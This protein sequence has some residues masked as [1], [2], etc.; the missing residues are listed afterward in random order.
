MEMKVTRRWQLTDLLHICGMENVSQSNYGD[1]G[2]DYTQSRTDPRPPKLVGKTSV[3][4]FRKRKGL[5]PDTSRVARHTLFEAMQMEMSGDDRTLHW[6]QP[7]ECGSQ[8]QTALEDKQLPA[9][10]DRRFVQVTLRSQAF[11]QGRPAQDNVLIDVEED[12][13]NSLYFAKYVSNCM[14]AIVI[15]YF[16]H[17]DPE[18][19]QLQVHGFFPR[20]NRYTLR[21]RSLVFGDPSRS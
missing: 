9:D 20:S 14:A 5:P 15:F 3:L 2:R 17:N 4:Q 12:N 13:G 6:K 21:S 1:P 18:M 8:L 19:S 16:L 11:Y 10:D 7:I